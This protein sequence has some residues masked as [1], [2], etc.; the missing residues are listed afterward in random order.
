MTASLLRR[1]DTFDQNLISAT[2][3]LNKCETHLVSTR[4]EIV[5]LRGDLAGLREELQATALTC[6]EIKGGLEEKLQAIDQILQKRIKEF[7]IS[8]MRIMTTFETLTKQHHDNQVL[9]NSQIND[10]IYKLQNEMQSDYSGLQCQFSQLITRFDE[11][12]KNLA[13]LSEQVESDEIMQTTLA[14]GKKDIDELS[15]KLQVSQT[16]VNKLKEKLSELERQVYQSSVSE[17]TLIPKLED[18]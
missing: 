6:S 1:I 16:E 17:V 4:D 2:Q 11:S 15:E 18:L 7:E 5:G 12:D 9:I 8:E 14:N 13:K 3:R 10:K